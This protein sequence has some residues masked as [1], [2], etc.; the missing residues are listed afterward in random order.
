MTSNAN[1]PDE[2]IN[3]LPDERQEVIKKIITVIQNNLPR[4]CQVN[5]TVVQE[6]SFFRN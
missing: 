4:G 5:S 2:Y 6:A 1:T 3:Q